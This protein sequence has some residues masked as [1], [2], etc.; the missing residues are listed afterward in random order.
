ML[1]WSKP[2]LPAALSLALLAPCAAPRGAAAEDA[3][4][5]DA[6]LRALERHARAVPLPAHG[7]AARPLGAV[8]SADGR[9]PCFIRGPVS[10]GTLSGT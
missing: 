1:R 8:L 3:L 7:F 10:R 4:K 6:G 2:I 9:I 5:I